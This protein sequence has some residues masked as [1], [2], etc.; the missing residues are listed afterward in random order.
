MELTYTQRVYGGCHADPRRE[1][2]TLGCERAGAHHVSPRARCHRFARGPRRDADRSDAW[3]AYT[4]SG[5]TV[6]TRSDQAATG[7]QLD[8]A[9]KHCHERVGLSVGARQAPRRQNVGLWL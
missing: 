4:S 7:E 8:R 3:P 2:H 5:A 1:R 6:T 9:V